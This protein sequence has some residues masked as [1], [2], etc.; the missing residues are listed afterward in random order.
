M[1]LVAFLWVQGLG[2]RVQGSGFRFRVQG[3]GFRLAFFK[4]CG[5]L[6]MTL[7]RCVRF[8]NTIGTH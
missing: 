6:Q 1:A 3:S 8:G 5:T 4:V 2:F 7:V